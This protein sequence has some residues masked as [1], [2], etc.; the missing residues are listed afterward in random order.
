MVS[1]SD[2]GEGEVA[3]NCEKTHFSLNTLYL[4]LAPALYKALLSVSS[5]GVIC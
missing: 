3:V 1:Y 4:S 5:T 2:V